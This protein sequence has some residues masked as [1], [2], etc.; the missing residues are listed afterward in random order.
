MCA[1][2][3]IGKKKVREDDRRGT[4]NYLKNCIVDTRPIESS[5]RLVSFYRRGAARPFSSLVNFLESPSLTT[6]FTFQRFYRCVSTSFVCV[7]TFTSKRD[8]G[9]LLTTETVLAHLERS[10]LNIPSRFPPRVV[11]QPPLLI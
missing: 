3:L 1:I 4:R 11:A 9:L 5:F 7:Q 8:Y 10:F 6:R 2:N